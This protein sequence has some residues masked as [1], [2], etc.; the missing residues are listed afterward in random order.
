MDDLFEQLI[1]DAEH[2]FAGW[3]FSYISKTK[4]EVE[5]PLPWSYASLLLPYLWQARSMLDMG[6]GGGEFLAR[7]RPLPEVT[8]A[9]EGYRPNVAVARE[10][11]EPLGVSVHEVSDDMR[12]PFPERHFDL[13]INRHESY[14]PAE[15]ARIL[16][17]GGHF[18]TQ[19]VGG[20][21]DN[22]LNSLLGAPPNDEFLHWN[23]EYA[24]REL[25]GSGLEVTW[26]DEAEINTRFYDIGAVVYYLKAVP[27]QIPGFSVGRYRDRLL[28]LHQDIQSHGYID[29]PSH[30]F[31]LLAHRRPA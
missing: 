10:L 31:I 26:S 30:R 24:L 23:L 14:S 3:D 15:V 29:I 28:S 17:P 2:T 22:E 1:A 11:L 16:K 20:E 7:L 13:V 18:I 25:D 8:A 6:T 12:L 9:T 27:W 19:Q 4:R 5:A 21:N